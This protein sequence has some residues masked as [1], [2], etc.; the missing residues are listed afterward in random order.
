MAQNPID[1]K[2]DQLKSE[3]IEKVNRFGVHKRSSCDCP[4]YGWVPIKFEGT[5]FKII[6]IINK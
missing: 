1:E 3:I 5:I 4:S 6:T 2:V